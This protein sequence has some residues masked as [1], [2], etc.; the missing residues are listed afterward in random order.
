MRKFG[1][2]EGL[3][4]TYGQEDT[5]RADDLTLRTRPVWKWMLGD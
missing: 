2:A 3:L 5:A 4:L 1:L